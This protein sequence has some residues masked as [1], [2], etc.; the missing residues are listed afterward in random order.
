[1]GN[2]IQMHP[3]KPDPMKYARFTKPAD[4][5][6]VE[7]TFRSKDWFGVVFAIILLFLIF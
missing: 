3:V 7:T 6:G 4:Y 1:M 5:C 2:V